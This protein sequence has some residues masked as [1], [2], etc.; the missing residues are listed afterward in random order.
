MLKFML[1]KSFNPI[2]LTIFYFALLTAALLFPFDFDFP[3]Q[4]KE[5]DV[6]WLSNSNGIELQSVGSIQSKEQPNK[7]YKSLVNGDGITL[8]IWLSSENIL[9]QGPARIVSYSYNKYLRN[10]T[11]GQTKGDLIFRLRTTESTL[12]GHEL[13]VKDVFLPNKTQHIV[14]T[15]NF[16]QESVYINGKRRQ[17]TSTLKGNFTNWDPYYSLVIGNELTGNRPW[18]GKVFLIAIYNRSLSNNEIHQNY[19]AGKQFTLNSVAKNTRVTDGLTAFYLFNEKNGYIVK[20]KSGLTPPINLYIP[21]ALQITNKVFLRP[22]YQDFS[23]YNFENLKD[24]IV[25]I[26]FFIPIG[27]FL[28]TLVYRQCQSPIKSIC[29]VI[30]MG[31]MFTLSIESIQYFLMSRTSSLTDVVHN[32]IA[33]IL[34]I[35]VN[36]MFF[37]TASGEG[38]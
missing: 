12:N 27:F 18:N 20:D 11:L 34:G 26:V 10:F 8:E 25:N 2:P 5:N 29:I 31:L 6:K 24:F 19:Q 35:I 14:V 30:S 7:L 9:Q 3:L 32:T 1:D 15:Y 36:K 33:V 22:P 16:L 4:T 28:Y 21:S 37:V 38:N 23:L 17:Q 13:Q